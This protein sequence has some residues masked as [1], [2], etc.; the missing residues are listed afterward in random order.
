MFG[1]LRINREYWTRY[2]VMRYWVV[3]WLFM[4][5]ILGL[6]AFVVVFP[7]SQGVYYSFTAFP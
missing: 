6:H 4:L 5:P 7:A 3:P 2:R 1:K